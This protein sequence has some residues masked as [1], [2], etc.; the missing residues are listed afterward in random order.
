MSSFQVNTFQITDPR[1]LQRVMHSILS[2]R[3]L[4][5][6]R[7]AAAAPTLMDTSIDINATQNEV[8]FQ[9][10]VSAFSPFDQGTG[11]DVSVALRNMRSGTFRRRDPNEEEDEGSIRR[12]SF[13]SSSGVTAV[14]K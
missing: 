4:L 8:V 3:V 14:N 13:P 5:N 2:S 7:Q 11:E 12:V 10:W 6:L 9:P 1:S